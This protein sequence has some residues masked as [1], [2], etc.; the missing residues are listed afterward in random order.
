MSR[1]A[2]KPL[3]AVL[4][5]VLTLA[6]AG[7][8]GAAIVTSSDLQGRRITLDVRA[9]AVDTDWY[10]GVLRA[11]VHGNEISNVTVRI[12]PDISI[13]GL[14]GSEAAA[15]YTR[16]GGRPTIIIPAGKNQFI[17]GTL[18]HEYG[19]HLDASTAVPGIPELNGIPVWWADRGMAALFASRKV[20]F[21]YS[22]GWDHSIAEIFAEDYAYIHVGPTYRYAITWLSPPDDKLKSDMFAALGGDADDAAAGGAERAARRPPRRDARPAQDEDRPVRPARP[23][24]PRDLHRHRLACDAQGRPRPHP[25]PLQR[26]SRRNADGRQGPEGPHARPAEHGA[27]RLRRPPRQLGAGLPEVQ[28][29]AAAR[30]RRAKPSCGSAV[31][32]P[33]DYAGHRQERAILGRKSAAWASPVCFRVPTHAHRPLRRE[34]LWHGSS[35]SPTKRAAW[36]KPPPR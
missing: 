25:G 22:M 15:C 33:H 23:R 34:L 1:A 16:A 7:G 20:A 26:R 28:P 31:R 9:N 18:V 36:P 6:L 8:A 4:A 19:H 27:G 21:D 3:V 30:G 2:M 29:P 17:E 11:T 32:D 35:R 10:A 14:C 24:P 5:L 12:V 13:E